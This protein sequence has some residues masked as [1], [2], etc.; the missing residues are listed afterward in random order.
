[1]ALNMIPRYVCG[2]EDQSDPYGTQLRSRIAY[3]SD[4]CDWAIG[5]NASTKGALKLAELGLREELI[6]GID[7]WK[8]RLPTESSLVTFD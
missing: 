6:G 4:K 2:I 3:P 5:C 1:M 8:R 7:W